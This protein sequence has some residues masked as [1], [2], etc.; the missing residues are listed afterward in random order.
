MPSVKGFVVA[1]CISRLKAHPDL[2]VSFVSD[3][4]SGGCVHW[5]LYKEVAAQFSWERAAALGKT[6]SGRVRVSPVRRVKGGGSPA[7]IG[8]YCGGS[9]GLGWCKKPMDKVRRIVDADC[10]DSVKEDLLRS[11]LG[12]EG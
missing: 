5:P 9:L 10:P 12:V 8:E 7:K 3:V 1:E 11:A 2:L 4:A 6:D